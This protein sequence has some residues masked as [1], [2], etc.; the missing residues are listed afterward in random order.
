M[1]VSV[2]ITMGFLI[3]LLSAFFFSCSFES[4]SEAISVTSKPSN[5]SPADNATN[6]SLSLELSWEADNVTDFDVYLDTINPPQNIYSSGITDKSLTVGLLNANTT[7]YWKVVA[8]PDS[9]PVESSV[10]TFATGTTINSE[11]SGDVLLL[12]QITAEKPS[13]VKMIFRV[14]DYFGNGI[15]TLTKDNFKLLEDDLAVSASESDIVISKKTDIIDTL[16]V[17]LMLDNSTSLTSN[18]ETIRASAAQL[19]YNL[20]T[21]TVDGVKLNVQVAV[22][23]FSDEITMLTDYISDGDRLYGV[24]WGNYA[25]GKSSTDLYGAVVKGASRWTDAMTSD[26]IR[27]GVMILFTDGSDT[28]GSTS[29]G[30]ALTA[31]SGKRVFTV[32]LGSD[33]DSVI[34]ENL[35]TAGYYE[36]STVSDLTSKFQEVQA[37]IL[38]YINSFYL[39][40]YNSPKRGNYDH[41]LRLSI[42]DNLNTGA[43]SYIQGY[44]NSYGF[45]SN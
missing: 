16:K 30:D 13:Y 24:V 40:T 5:P 14:V 4:S 23:S 18:I 31:V 39:L 42:I 29:V 20:A 10:W 34:L 9:N 11:Q 32:G 1:S 41:L 33:I 26:K 12:Q 35:G 28:Q 36:I 15:G 17:V 45:Y 21:M 37:E 7:Y 19:A 43:G 8:D 2:R 3:L 22:Y 6:Q 44:Y 38:D 25:L 27:Q